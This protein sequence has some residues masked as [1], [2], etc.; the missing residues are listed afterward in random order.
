LDLASFLGVVGNIF[1]SVGL[2]SYKL[3][4]KYI[5]AG[6]ISVGE[7]HNLGDGHISLQA[8]FVS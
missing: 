8:T 4:L 7:G 1:L 2:S 3:G 5:V 6:M